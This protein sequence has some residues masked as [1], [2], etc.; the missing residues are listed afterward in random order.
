MTHHTVF[1]TLIRCSSNTSSHVI[2]HT[3]SV[4]YF[5]LS[6]LYCTSLRR[7][8]LSENPL[9]SPPLD[10]IS[11]GGGWS[12]VKTFLQKIKDCRGAGS[13]GEEGG[14][15]LL[16]SMHFTLLPSMVGL[17]VR[18]ALGELEFMRLCRSCPAEAAAFFRFFPTTL[19]NFL[20]NSASFSPTSSDTSLHHNQKPVQPTSAYHLAIVAPQVPRHQF[21][22]RNSFAHKPLALSS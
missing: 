21:Q 20:M 3:S 9:E 18:V 12:Y 2:I 4:T 14:Q 13:E 22:P 6:L 7:I 16:D 17:S 10:C 1:I 8:D 5:Q 19:Q 15:L 11:Q